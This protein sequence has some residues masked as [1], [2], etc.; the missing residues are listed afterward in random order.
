MKYHHRKCLWG[1]GCQGWVGPRGVT[2]C[3]VGV[4]VGAFAE[5]DGT[6]SNLTACRRS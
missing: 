1:I 6:L 4:Q 5:L 2:M 3:G